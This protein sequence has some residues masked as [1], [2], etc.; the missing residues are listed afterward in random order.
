MN[1]ILVYAGEFCDS[2]P[3]LMMFVISLVADVFCSLLLRLPR[4]EMAL[5]RG[6]SGGGEDSLL[7]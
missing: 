4:D 2:V 1:I 5:L 6:P 3:D 7:S